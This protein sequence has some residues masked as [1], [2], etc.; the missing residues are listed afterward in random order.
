MV[1]NQ[2]PYQR[3]LSIF[4]TAILAITSV[5]GLSVSKADLSEEYK[6]IECTELLSGIARL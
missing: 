3:R 1:T 2:G 6:R 5:L 4:L